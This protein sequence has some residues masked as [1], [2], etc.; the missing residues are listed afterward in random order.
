MASRPTPSLDDYPRSTFRQQRNRA[1]L[2]RYEPGSTFKIV[3][4]AAALEEGVVRPDTA[5]DCRGG[6]IRI[7]NRTYRDHERFGVL[8]FADVVRHSS[9]VGM[10]VVTNRLKSGV[11]ED[12]ARRFGF[13]SV[14]EVGLW[15]SAGK[16][17][18]LARSPEVGHASLSIGYGVGVTAL[19][20]AAAVSAVANDGLRPSPR[21]VL[22]T[23]SPGGRWFPEEETPFRRVVSEETARTLRRL[24]EGVVDGGT[25]SL[26]RV[27]G[28]RVAGKTGTAR[29]HV[30]GLGYVSSRY[31]ASFAGF[32]PVQDPRVVCVVVLDSPDGDR[33]YGGQTAAP[34][35]SRIVGEALARLR[36][37]STDA[38]RMARRSSPDASETGVRR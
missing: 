20:M 18:D 8:S 38:I 6:E 32:A 5:V 14:T 9:N 23:R 13:G 1:V 3:S 21:V 24:L 12:Y 37:P 26:A 34:V 7:R 31:Y 36:V 10:I 27:P 33:Y 17:P 19:Q 2:D 15:E 22:G 29:R 30:E 16:L 35:F 28:Y 4:A 11:L 25:G